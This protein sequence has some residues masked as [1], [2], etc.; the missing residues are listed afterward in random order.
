[1]SSRIA[2]ERTQGWVRLM[3][4]TPQPPINYVT[5]KIIANLLVNVTEVV[6]LFLAAAIVEHVRMPL[7]NWIMA[8]AWIAFGGLTFI[9]L[10]MLIGQ[11]AGIDA[12]QIVAS[13]LY[14]LLSITGGLWFPVQM[15]GSFMSH[16]AQWTPTYHLARVSWSLVAGQAPSWDDFLVLAAYF[17]AFGLVA[18]WATG[19]RRDTR[20]A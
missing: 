7:A 2:F 1:M 5:A 19:R 14:F 9:V 12:A 18:L 3:Q 15:M 20:S 16:L 8:G 17:V 13:A 11:L 10:G 6:I 4:T